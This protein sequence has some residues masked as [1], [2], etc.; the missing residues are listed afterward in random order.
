MLPVCGAVC[1]NK[2]GQVNNVNNVN[3]VDKVD[4]VDNT[5]VAK[6]GQ[7]PH[8]REAI[9]YYAHVPF[10]YTVHVRFVAYIAFTIR[11]LRSYNNIYS[12]LLL[13]PTLYR[14]TTTFLLYAVCTIHTE[15]N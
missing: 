1:V 11:V 8:H 7:L 13:L 3:N 14:S 12:T 2:G 10:L 4:K 9:L 15:H 5:E 6:I